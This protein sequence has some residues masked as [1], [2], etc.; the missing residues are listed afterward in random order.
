MRKKIPICSNSALVCGTNSYSAP[1]FEN[2]FLQ[3]LKMFIVMCKKYMNRY[4]SR[5]AFFFHCYTGCN[6][7]SAKKKISIDAQV[8]TSIQSH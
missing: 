2:E 4:M 5:M 8:V 3:K 7:C 1:F 6:N